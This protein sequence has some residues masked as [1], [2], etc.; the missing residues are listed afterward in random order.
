MIDQITDKI[1]CINL[2]R[3]PDRWALAVDQ[4]EKHHLHVERFAAID[5]N[6]FKINYPTDNGNNGCTLS[7]YFLIE[8]AK[9]LGFKAV[10]I[11]EDD[12][13]LHTAFTTLLNECI[14]QLPADW[15]M[16]YFGGSHREQ[17]SPVNERILRVNKTLTTHGY[18]LRSTMFDQVIS[19][20]KILDNPVDCF[21]AAWQKR[22]NVYITNPPIA[23]QR[24]GFSD[25][26]KREMHYEWIKT[27]YQ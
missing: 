24:G 27:N 12:V 6:D 15:D 18:I 22:F 17:P 5:G 25:I 21:Y 14:Y 23:W 10:M 9:I 1:Y 16:L 8:R 20:F 3:R 13:E 19:N 26:C 2:D 4:F 11:F 7:H